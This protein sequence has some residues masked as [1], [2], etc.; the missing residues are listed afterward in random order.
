[1]AAESV[2]RAVAAAPLID[3]HVHSVVSDV[4]DRHGFER[5]LT[6]SAEPAAPGFSYF[7]SFLGAALV[8]TC[9]PVLD[10]APSAS[11]QEYLARRIE[12]GGEEANRRLLRRGGLA[13]LLVDHG[14]HGDDL[15]ELPE[16]ATIAGTPVR[17]IAR[18]EQVAEA[19]A[20]EGVDADGR[21]TRSPSGWRPS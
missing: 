9:A 8:R 2:V 12:L 3:H 14:Y 16:L 13:A 17:R 20:G 6:E 15:L 1:M 11:A 19:V 18:L 7:D 21:G 10:L 5:F 4:R